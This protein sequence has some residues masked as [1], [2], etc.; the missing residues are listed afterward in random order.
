MLLS[1]R[2]VNG[3]QFDFK[4]KVLF[5]FSFSVLFLSWK[6]VL[7]GIFTCRLHCWATGCHH[8]IR[9]Y[10]SLHHS[11]YYD[12]DDC[13][14]ND[15][16]CDENVHDECNENHNCCTTMTMI[17]TMTMTMTMMMTRFTC[18]DKEELGDDCEE[19]S[20][21]PSSN[22]SWKMTI[23]ITTVLVRIAC[24]D[25]LCLRHKYRHAS[26]PS[27]WYRWHYQDILN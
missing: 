21:E 20:P 2:F 22:D 16:R 5:V 17:W 23:L 19:S 15:D 8:F 24:A 10:H 14:Y 6:L 11:D 13:V 1:V 7:V 18:I 9:G 26:V 4:W 25:S 12:D 27:S 3:L